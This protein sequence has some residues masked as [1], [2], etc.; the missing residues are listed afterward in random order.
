MLYRYTLYRYTSACSKGITVHKLAIDNTELCMQTASV[1]TSRS[2]Q[3]TYRPKRS[4][5]RRN[6]AT[7]PNFLGLKK[8]VRV[9]RAGV[10]RQYPA[11]L[12]ACKVSIK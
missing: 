12:Q 10:L 3:S 6:A 11:R 7:A 1:Y 8:Y 5:P 2:L 4:E 9:V